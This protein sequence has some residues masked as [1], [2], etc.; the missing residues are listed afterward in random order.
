MC[1]TRQ[2]IAVVYPIA[3]GVQGGYFGY[4]FNRLIQFRGGSLGIIDAHVRVYRQDLGVVVFVLLIHGQHGGFQ[5]LIGIEIAIVLGRSIVV[6]FTQSRQF[7]TAAFDGDTT[8][9]HQGN[10]HHR[11]G[12]K[13]SFQ[14][15]IF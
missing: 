13:Y 10:S 7:L 12:V 3:F 15:R 1:F 5:N 2:K 14:G 4:L 9:N 11:K 6:D 8:L